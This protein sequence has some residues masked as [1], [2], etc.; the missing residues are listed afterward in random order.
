MSE[1]TPGL[2]RVAVELRAW[3]E[4]L[5]LAL[6]GERACLWVLSEAADRLQAALCT[7]E[8]EGTPLEVLL[9][10]HALGWVVVE[11]VSLRASRRDIFREAPDG[12]VVAAPVSERR[13]ER[14]GCVAME[15][16]GVPRLDAPRALE[17]AAELTGRLLGD[18][19]ATEAA[20]GDVQKYEELYGAIHDLDRELDLGELAAGVARR[21]RSVAGARG[22]VV[23]SWDP[24]AK[25]GEIVATEGDVP[26]KLSGARLDGESSFLG[27][28]VSNATVLPRDDLTGGQRFPLY[29]D[30]VA[31]MAGSAI[32]VPMI[33]DGDAIG[34]LAVEYEAP[35][36]YIER[37]LE[38][39]KVLALFVGPAFR[40][41]VEFGEV[42]QL[43][44][45]DTLT[46]LPNRRSTERVLA[47]TIAVA[48]RTGSPFA[49][50]VADVDHFKRINDR[51]GHEAGDTVLQAVARVMRETIRPG[52]HAG[53]WGGEEYLVVLPATALEDAARAVERLRRN[54]ELLQIDWE[55]RP[56]TVT[57]SAGLT[58]Y[59]ELIR[60]AAAA[61]ASADAALYKAK[62]AG[63]NTV[64]VAEMRGPV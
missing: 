30:G 56:L 42:K 31:S 17:L 59:P 27:L 57:I 41:A 21:A 58:A 32:I 26:R 4:S 18:V 37:D 16:G 25:Q 64:A 62:R 63:R 50:A 1:T 34:A 61:V 33:V 45:T 51:Y 20:L 49:V 22:A 28:A 38:R 3:L 7:P 47:S 35:R 44:L 6:G 43:S 8:S 2:E 5:R 60:N 12:W 40:N 23:A 24:T 39:L 53:R 48:E 19:R 36:G 11:G 46:G 9:H 14:V 52:D 54:V 10:G 29:V 13:G 15:F 55:G